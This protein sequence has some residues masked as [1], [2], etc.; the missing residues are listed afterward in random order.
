M[1]NEKVHVLAL[2][3]NDPGA[4]G[5]KATEN[6]TRR[7]ETPQHP[8]A[9]FYRRVLGKRWVEFCSAHQV[10]APTEQ[11]WR[12]FETQ[13]W[14]PSGWEA[15]LVYIEVNKGKLLSDEYILE[16]NK[17]QSYSADST[18]WEHYPDDMVLLDI[19]KHPEGVVNGKLAVIL[20]EIME[21]FPQ[22]AL[23]LVRIMLRADE[24]VRALRRIG[25][26]ERNNSP[27]SELVAQYIQSGQRIVERN[28]LNFKRAYHLEGGLV[29]HAHLTKIEI[30]DLSSK[31]LLEQLE[32]YVILEGIALNSLVYVL[33]TGA[34]DETGVADKL[35]Q[36]CIDVNHFFQGVMSGNIYR[37]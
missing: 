24:S 15:F 32:R 31:Q 17:Y 29:E 9:G 10:S 1:Q 16:L 27:S 35:Y 14:E 11:T 22:L 20:P 19:Q 12:M 6:L 5:T 36:L 23:P 25:R 3:T 34:L 37:E 2:I 21:N 13:L 33:D 18:R 30:N 26:E 4:G 28:E 8:D 7:M